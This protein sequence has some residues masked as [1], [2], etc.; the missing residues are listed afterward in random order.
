MDDEVLALSYRII[1]MGSLGQGLGCILTLL[2]FHFTLKSGESK[3]SEAI[4][5]NLLAA[6]LSFLCWG[7]TVYHHHYNLTHDQ[8]YSWTLYELSLE[9][10]QFIMLTIA[11][12]FYMSVVSALYGFLE[13]WDFEI[14]LYWCICTFTTI[15]FGDYSP[16][17]T[18]G[19]AFLPPITFVGIGLVGSNMWSLRN[20]L[21]EFLA[22]QL[23]SQYSKV[24]AD[25]QLKVTNSKKK[26][27][28]RISEPVLD[29]HHSR[30]DLDQQEFNLPSSSRVAIPRHGKR[31]NISKSPQQYRFGVI[32]QSPIEENVP[33][34]EDCEDDP[35][36]LS[37]TPVANNMETK[38]K[39]I[40]ITR[41]SRLPSVVIVGNDALKKSHIVETTQST[42]SRQIVY[43]LILVISNILVSGFIFSYL[44]KWSI[45]EGIYFSYCSFMTIGYGDYTLK[46]YLARSIFIWFIFFAIGSSTYLIAMLSELAVDQWTVTTNCIAKRVDR[47]EVKAKLK[48]KFTLKKGK[49]KQESEDE[50]PKS[51]AID[52]PPE[53][54]GDYGARQ[55]RTFM[56]DIA[57][58]D[59]DVQRQF[60]RPAA[61][62]VSLTRSE[63]YSRL[64]G[65][66]CAMIFSAVGAAYGTAKSGIGIAGLGQVK[67]ELMMKSLIPVVM[68]GIIGVYGLVIAVLIANDLDPTKGYS[69]FA[70]CVHLAAGLSVGF[71]GIAGGYAIGLVGDAG[72][73]SYIYQPRMFVGMVLI[74]IFAEVLGLYGMII[75]LILN[76]KATSAC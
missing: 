11:S 7:L 73:R 19:M 26:I 23:A 4:V 39:T 50:L 30:S 53:S 61:Y 38:P 25:S 28:R 72:V 49:E 6:S 48:K 75:G 55:S 12:I 10:R 51:D 22:I 2:F 63:E 27:N 45:L 52:I 66:A 34:L 9:Q 33:L 37:Q 56:P 40:R 46:T 14:G 36:D 60:D 35:V 74:L 76:T 71:S 67:P 18:C 24:Y 42:I 16:K 59:G 17:T 32:H 1:M 15:G 70:G 5:Y 57:S 31:A 3:Y 8:L 20:V 41:N 21:L 58:Y 13:D 65:A 44:E 68:A 29:L 54:L 62:S 43:S 47:Y 69:L 64:A